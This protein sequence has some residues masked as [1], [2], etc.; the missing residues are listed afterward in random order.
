MVLVP[1]TCGKILKFVINFYH[2]TSQ[3][4]V[5]GNKTDI[6]ISDI[7]DKLGSELRTR[8]DQ[9]DIFNI[10][11]VTTLNKCLIQDKTP[12]NNQIQSNNENESNFN[13]SID[14]T[15]SDNEVCEICP[16]C[17][18]PAYGKV[19]QCGECGEWHHY[20]GINI[21]DITIEILGSDDFICTHCIDNL[22]YSTSK[23]KDHEKSIHLLEPEG[24]SPSNENDPTSCD[25]FENLQAIRDQQKQE[26]QITL[27]NSTASSENRTISEQNSE[28]NI[29][30]KPKRTVKNTMKIKKDDIA[31]KSYI[32]D[33]ENQINIL[34]S[35]LNFY[36]KS[37]DTNQDQSDIQPPFDSPESRRQE[38][39]R[40]C[41]HTCSHNCCADL[42]DKIQENRMRMLEMQ[43]MQNLYIN[44]A[45]HIQLASQIRPQYQNIAYPYPAFMFPGTTGLYRGPMNPG[46]PTH[47]PPPTYLNSHGYHQPNVAAFQPPKNINYQVR[48]PVYAPAPANQPLHHRTVTTNIPM[49][50][51][52]HSDLQQSSQPQS[53]F[54]NNQR[55]HETFKLHHTGVTNHVPERNNHQMFKGPLNSKRGTCDIGKT[56]K[57]NVEQLVASRPTSSR[58]RH[59]SDR[60]I[61]SEKLHSTEKSS[62]RRQ[63]PI[64][65][66]DITDPPIDIHKGQPKLPNT[67]SIICETVNLNTHLDSLNTIHI[68]ESPEK[69]KSIDSPNETQPNHHFLL[70][71]PRKHNPPE[72]IQQMQSEELRERA[73]PRAT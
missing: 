63:P 61:Q 8:C 34:K 9:L 49:I 67:E 69:A 25:N 4:L 5:N 22:K 26:P 24:K 65:K 12:Q 58:K 40:R 37:K 62:V 38:H 31:D 21:S 17:Q 7:L 42:K 1:N 36:N 60:Q 30:A 68:S 2:T 59:S 56:S 43:M 18:K 20:E 39:S 6:F 10:N 33:L 44:N 19:V 15:E 16:I 57:N 48:P 47:I 70:L 45:L 52:A 53:L 13:L 41:D 27:L 66:V 28:N 71:P 73:L 55:Q 14:E 46:F 3:I 35:T 23:K 29:K 50:P 72:L 54:H 51:T 32:L 11:I 64:S